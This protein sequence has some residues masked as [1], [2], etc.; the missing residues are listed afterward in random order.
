MEEFTIYLLKSAICT[1][2]FFGIYWCFLKNETFHR[3]NRY[4]LITGFLCAFLLPFLQYNYTITLQIPAAAAQ[5]EEK[6]AAPLDSNTI[7]LWLY[8]VMFGYAGVACLLII[9]HIS[10]LM[11][12]G[13][14]IRQN[15]YTFVEGYKLIATPVFKSSFSVFNYIFI[16]ISP[17]TSEKEKTLIIAHELAHV[18]QS[19]WVDL[20]LAQL[21]CA[22]QWFNPFAWLYLHAIKENHEFLADAAVL[23]KGN[24][25]A[26][27]R[28]A[29][30]NHS[31]KTPVFMFASSFGNY[32]HFKRIKMMT[33]TASKP[34][35][36][37]AVLIVIP[38]C[39]LFLFAF[40]KPN[41][42]IVTISKNKTA[43]PKPTDQKATHISKRALHFRSPVQKVKKPVSK[44]VK[45]LA[46]TGATQTTSGPVSTPPLNE[47]ATTVTYTGSKLIVMDNTKVRSKENY[48][49]IIYNGKTIP[50]MPDI[51]NNDI[52]SINVFKGDAAINKYG[53]QGKNGVI[54]I[55]SK[56]KPIQSAA[57]QADRD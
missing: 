9:R 30:L 35:K 40:A 34:L 50:A 4:F 5:H 25:V 37:L 54:E 1:T 20:L 49:L 51:N 15:G 55:I 28:A 6:I 24:S 46:K 38:A 13:K 8:A 56:T 32:N 57:E 45:R 43:L 12:L 22:L 10:G 42:V 44:Q 19:H 48:P 47:T 36:K 7:P 52:N 27:Y 23:Q 29:L 11:H 26:V 39:A 31:L 53:E 21:V 3:F 18:K 16:A 33:K 41:Y 17:D 14:M 2:L